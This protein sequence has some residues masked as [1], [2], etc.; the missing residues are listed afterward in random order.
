MG[1]SILVRL[2]HV[3]HEQVIAGL[4]PPGNLLRRHLRVRLAPLPLEHVE[5]SQHQYF[6]TIMSLVGLSSDL[7][8]CNRQAVTSGRRRV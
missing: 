7:D 4:Q 1:L 5:C 3:E 6:L 8:A 2:P